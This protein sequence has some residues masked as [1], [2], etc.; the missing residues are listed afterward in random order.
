MSTYDDNCI[1][2][3]P[4]R[5]PARYVFNAGRCADAYHDFLADLVEDRDDTPTRTL[6]ILRDASAP[7]SNNELL[8]IVYVRRLRA[9]ARLS[10]LTWP[11]LEVA[12][13]KLGRSHNEVIDCVERL[14]LEGRF[15][16][17][18]SE[19]DGEEFFHIES[20]PADDMDLDLREQRS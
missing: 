18:T 3:Q 19:E 11:L 8:F 12:K 14:I 15:R 10:I 6:E 7:L 16:V 5:P 17:T 9:M 4:N 2:D 13:T 1:N 20:V